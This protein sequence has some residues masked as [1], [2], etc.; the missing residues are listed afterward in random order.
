VTPFLIVPIVAGVFSLLLAVSSL[1][2]RKRTPAAWFFFAGMIALG[3][4]SVF[5]GLSFRA[6]QLGDVVAWLLPALVAKSF[7]PVTWLAFSLT[8]SRTNYR[9]FLKR[10]ALALAFLGTLPIA[11]LSVR[12]RSG[13]SV[14]DL[15]WLQSGAAA[16]VLNSVLLISLVAIL[17]NLEQTFRA[18]VGTMRWRVKF[19]IVA[20]AVIFGARLYVRIQ[21]ML[22]LAPDITQWNVESGALL[23]GCVLLTVAYVRTRWEE[24][25]LYP[26]LAFMRS[27]LTTVVVGAYLLVVGIL[28]QTVQRFGGAEMFQFQAVVV[29]VG[30]AGL[31]LLL[32]SDRRR[33]KLHAFV[34]RHFR[35]AQHD[36]AR[37]WTLFSQ[38]LTGI[39]DARHLCDASTRLI[40]DTF[41]VLSVTMWLFDDERRG[42]TLGATT[43]GRQG[44]G[45]E[46]AFSPAVSGAI[47]AG[48]STRRSP[49]DLDHVF[50]PWADDLRRANASDFVTGGH[51]L[52][53]PLHAERAVLGIIVLADRVGGAD[54]TA[55]ELELL[56]CIG[57]QLTAVILNLRLA[58]EVARSRELEAFRTM[59]AFFVHDLKNTAA[60]LNLMLKNLPVHFDDPAFRQD[61]LRAI[62]NTARRIDETIARLGALRDR[63]ETLRIDTDLNQVVSD[64]L[65]GVTVTPQVELTRALRPVP[66]VVADRDQM[67]SVVTNLVLNA[68]DA[69][70]SG[71]AIRV[72]TEYQDERVTLSVTDNGCGMSQTFINQSLYRPFQSTKK[73]GLGIGLFQTRAIVQAHGGSMHVESEPGKGTTFVVTLPVRRSN[74]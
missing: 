31:A 66:A 43:R 36:S 25:D 3:L 67:Q 11:V 19:V 54:Y 32:L 37:V 5:T 62:G 6:A 16:T 39:K 68:R 46:R 44:D 56:E 38:R 63:P 57:D 35:K 20:L 7:V 15:W 64:A 52:V 74:P 26:S 59:S 47:A 13:F 58:S 27:S 73:K 50:E 71:G 24:S 60:S 55:E 29:L 34:A 72:S 21:A 30:I 22:F 51:R 33:Q 53:V 14:E 42:L 40:S 2:R 18:A 8:Y 4:D 10:W 1:A 23:I 41:D 9:E 61:A 70:T 28:A 65:D 45:A 12:W 69:L 17:M 49:F 48:L